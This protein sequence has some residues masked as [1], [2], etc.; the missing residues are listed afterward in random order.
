[1]FQ[2]FKGGFNQLM[3]LNSYLDV[4]VFLLKHRVIDPM[5]KA[6]VYLAI[7]EQLLIVL[8]D[9]A[10]KFEAKTDLLPSFANDAMVSSTAK[11]AVK[12]MKAE[13]Q[14]V[15]QNKP[16]DAYSHTLYPHLAMQNMHFEV[17]ELA[18]RDKLAQEVEGFQHRASYR[19]FEIFTDKFVNPDQVNPRCSEPMTPE[20]AQALKSHLQMRI[21]DFIAKLFSG[22]IRA[23]DV[24]F[25]Y[26]HHLYELFPNHRAHCEVICKC[27]TVLCEVVTEDKTHA[28]LKE[29]QQLFYEAA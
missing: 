18:K 24:S 19:A 10:E 27:L 21:N 16:F 3:V 1:M 25:E 4:F 8:E 12:Y 6:P 20:E 26:V 11:A 23:S 17:E 5:A 2:L 28:F 7:C 9:E 13:K 15:S 29:R 22:G 14:Y